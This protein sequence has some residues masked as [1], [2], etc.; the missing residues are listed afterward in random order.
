MNKLKKFFTATL[1]TAL[2][3]CL[4]LLSAGGCKKD[5]SVK[6]EFVVYGE[7][8]IT[9]SGKK[10]NDITFPDDPTR[11]GFIFDGW[12]TDASFA[13]SPVTS[14]K[15]D[16]ETTY[17]A[18]W[19]VGCLIVLQPEGGTLS[20][21]K[22]YVRAGTPVLSAVADYVPE[23]GDLVF[24]GWFVGDKELTSDVVATVNGLTLT[25]KYKAKFV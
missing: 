21:D 20:T 9:V 3:A 25:A 17:Y 10:G 12:Y 1:I 23:K 18:K 11:E 2:L 4:F 19:E 24:G 22:V 5:D 7:E 15:F 14:G 13:G 6:N 16:G 8:T